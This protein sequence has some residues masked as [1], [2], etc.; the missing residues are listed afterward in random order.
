MQCGTLVVDVTDDAFWC[1]C[2]FCLFL[3]Q[4]NEQFYETQ[5]YS[6][7]IHTNKS[8]RFLIGETETSLHTVVQSLTHT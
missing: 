5:M 1:M 4:E 7:C 8:A 2:L 6:A 3:Q